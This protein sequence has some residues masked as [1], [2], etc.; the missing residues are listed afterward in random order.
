MR[1]HEAEA[2]E[3][4]MRKNALSNIQKGYLPMDQ[5]QPQQP[6]KVSAS[7]VDYGFTHRSAQEFLGIYCST[8][9]LCL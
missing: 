9:Q 6:Q 4:A 7:V 2:Q 8:S 5:Q 1:Q 3:S